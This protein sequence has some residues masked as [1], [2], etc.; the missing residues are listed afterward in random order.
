[1]MQ[2]IVQSGP[3]SVDVVD[4][5]R[6]SITEDQ[7]LI[8]VHS[9]GVCG[10]DAHAYQYEGGYEWV[11]IPR[12]MG[13][14]YSGEIV[15]VG[16]NVDSFSP[17]D[18]VVE[19]PTR[20]CGTCFQCKNGQ[21]NVCQNFSLKGMHR[22][23]SYAEYTIGEPS[24]L[25]HVPDAVPLDHAAIAE[26]L[27]IAAR[28]VLSRSVLKPGETALVE[29]PGP[30]GTLVASI[31][32]SIGAKV[33]VSG[34]ERDQRYRLPLVE[35]FGVETVDLSENDL[36]EISNSFTDGVGFDVVF[37]ST[38]HHTG[39]ELGVN[40]VRK[41]GQVVV[42]GLPGSESR[43]P[44]SQLVRSE[45]M[46]NTS[47]GSSWSNFEQALSLLEE[48]AIDPEVVIDTSFDYT[49]PEEAFSAFFKSETCKPMFS[50]T[51]Q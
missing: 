31:A 48:N 10:S 35:E 13:H 25:H 20:T 46:L 47:Y 39:I 6:P 14:E 18:R 43:L 33:L 49:D 26:P 8:E 15:E 32:R 4:R 7:V 30:I 37:D 42:V 51:E 12:I 41:G 44:L 17:G 28:T 34:L 2:A 36:D 38:G 22:D 21:S 5:K 11:E 50:F 29:G 27:S 40:Q 9:T 16:A 45:V 23:G 1:M 24:K 19:E 3:E